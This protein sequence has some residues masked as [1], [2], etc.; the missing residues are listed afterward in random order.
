MERTIHSLVV[1]NEEMEIV[2][3]SAYQNENDAAKA[4]VD[5]YTKTKETLKEEGWDTDGLDADELEPNRYRIQ[6]GDSSYC[7]EVKETTLY[8]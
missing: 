8:E 1:I 6:Y 3:V 5:D 4:L 7:A 2:S